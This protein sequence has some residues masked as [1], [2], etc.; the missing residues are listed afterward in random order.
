LKNPILTVCYLYNILELFLIKE[1][2]KKRASSYDTKIKNKFDNAISTYESI[3][4]GINLKIESFFDDIIE[5]LKS[6]VEAELS[7]RQ[8]LNIEL[9]FEE[10]I[11]N[12]F[13]ELVRHRC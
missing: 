5:R 8:R 9:E 13:D 4:K 11:M 10:Y 1:E 12:K 7:S 3:K 2:I 6:L